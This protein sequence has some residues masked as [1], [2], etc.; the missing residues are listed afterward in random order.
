MARIYSGTARSVFGSSLCTTIVQTT[1]VPLRHAS[2]VCTSAGNMPRFF[3]DLDGDESSDE[4]NVNPGD[5][6][7]TCLEYSDDE[8]EP[9]H[10]LGFR[11]STHFSLDSD[12]ED[13]DL[14]EFKRLNGYKD[15]YN[16][17]PPSKERPVQR[18]P[19]LSSYRT[20]RIDPSVDFEEDPVDQ[21]NSGEASRLVENLGA[22]MA[23]A[24]VIHAPPQ[25]PALPPASVDPDQARQDQAMQAFIR[26]RDAE[27]DEAEAE[28]AKLLKKEASEATAKRAE[29][30]RKQEA[31]AAAE[32]KRLAK[33]QEEAAARKAKEEQKESSKD[34]TVSPAATTPTASPA[35][36]TQSSAK[37]DYE[38]RAAKLT[39]QLVDVRK[40]VEPFEK[41]KAVSKRRLGMKK[42][43]NGKVNTLSNAE[44]VV[45]VA[46]EVA[47]TIQAAK[48]EDEQIK[49]QLAAKAPNV[50]PEMAKGKR[51]LVDLLASKVI[52]RVQADGFN[53]YVMSFI[54][55]HQ[56][57]LFPELGGMA[58]RWRECWR[59][60]P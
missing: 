1:V 58:F 36:A 10:P 59:I 13:D 48:T 6:V 51:Y 28:L 42:I 19:P 44:K 11:S 9:A 35:K 26:K 17:S 52:V 38:I 18:Y 21:C 41:S 55:D 34:S 49:Q 43:V 31:N 2:S 56:S 24:L 40:S 33:E 45:S 25:V 57:H 15:T 60:F 30:A 23:Q 8:E 54:A 20:K 12:S 39:Q 32:A 3:L 5:T 14:A 16:R 27:N 7:A 46:S 4:E 50:T 37:Q 29:V 47:A 22:I 53:G